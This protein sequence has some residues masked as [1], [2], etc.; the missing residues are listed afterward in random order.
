MNMTSHPFADSKVTKFLQERLAEISG[1]KSERQ[2]AAEAGFR[3][4]NIVNMMKKGDAKVPLDRAVGLANALGVDPAHFFVLVLDQY[5]PADTPEGMLMT[6]LL[7]NKEKEIIAFIREISEGSDPG[8]NQH[9]REALL[10]AFGSENFVN[11][12]DITVAS[13]QA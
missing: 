4:L 13:K 3:S 10:S 8:L 7:S 12:T 11:N 5:L 2:V 1:S 9:R 6:T